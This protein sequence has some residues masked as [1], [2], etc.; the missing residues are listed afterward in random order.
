MKK[1]LAIGAL[2]ALAT[3]SYAQEPDSIIQVPDTITVMFWGDMMSHTTQVKA[4]HDAVNDTYDYNPCFEKVKEAISGADI[5]V[6]NLECTLAGKPYK[7]YPCFSAPD[8]YFEAMVNNGFDVFLTANNHCIDTGKRGLELTREKLLKKD[9]IQIG[10]YKDSTDRAE[11]YPAIIEIRGVKIAMLCYTYGTNGI[12]VTEPNVVNY[13]DTAQIKLDIEESKS[14]GAD[15]IIANMHWGI[16][17][18]HTPRKSQKELAHW[19]I[20]NGVDHV[21]GGHPHVV[22]PAELFKG[23]DGRE[24][25]IVYSLGNVLANTQQEGGDGGIAVTLRLPASKTYD[26]PSVSYSIYHTARPAW[27]KVSNYTI[28]PYEYDSESLPE[29]EKTRMTNFIDATKKVMS[30]GSDIPLKPM[31]IDN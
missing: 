27:S 9:I 19:L 13:T 1:R 18:E 17:Y 14:R 26:K 12:K 30:E 11:R 29:G 16:E 2:L 23:N 8:Q 24:H 31:T 4:A 22:Q 15:Y 7:G 20:N 3:S 10:T 6:C 28:F 21:I 5:A 25:F